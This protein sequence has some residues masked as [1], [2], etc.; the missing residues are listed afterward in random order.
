[1]PGTIPLRPATPLDLPDAG[2]KLQGVLRNA[3]APQL[4]E[5]YAARAYRTQLTKHDSGILL[6]AWLAC[7]M[8][9]LSYFGL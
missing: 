9:M 8:M 7:E 4:H 1:M 6:L 2:G 3:Y 5:W